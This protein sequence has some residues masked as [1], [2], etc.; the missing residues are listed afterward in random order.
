M[1]TPVATPTRSDRERWDDSTSRI[2]HGF[3]VVLALF[4]LW[5]VNNLLRWDLLPFL[6]D[7]FDRVVPLVNLSLVVNLAVSAL[8]FVHPRVWLVAATELVT[9]AAGLPALVRT[10]RVFPFD[11]RGHRVPWELG[12]RVLLVVAIVGSVLGFLAALARLVRVAGTAA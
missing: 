7:D 5:V 6:T 4:G 9:I 2:G 1:A 11:V 8:R 10:W 3:G 12:L